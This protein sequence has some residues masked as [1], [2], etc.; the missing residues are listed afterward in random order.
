MRQGKGL[1]IGRGYPAE[2]P[3]GRVAPIHPKGRRAAR[4]AAEMAKGVKGFVASVAVT[5]DN[6]NL[7]GDAP[8]NPVQ[9]PAEVNP[10]QPPNLP[11][12]APCNPVQAPAEVNPVV[13]GAEVFGCHVPG[14]GRTF[15]TKRALAAHKGAHNKANRRTT[16]EGETDTNGNRAAN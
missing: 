5:D 10:A 7:P 9:A 8:C 6:L 3:P 12:D 11:G 14:C 15:T 13:I 4:K 16:A 2:L 1:I